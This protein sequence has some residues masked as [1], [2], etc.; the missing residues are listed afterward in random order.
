MTDDVAR[1]R[2]AAAQMRAELA[3]ESGQP[4]DPELRYLDAVIRLI[5]LAADE[6]VAVDRVNDRSRQH[7]ERP[8]AATAP[9]QGT[10]PSGPPR[11]RPSTPGRR[12]TVGEDS[13]RVRSDDTGRRGPVDRRGAQDL[14][15]RRVPSLEKPKIKKTLH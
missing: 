11:C 13:E 14:T 12:R 7:A 4:G 9:A 3:D 15:R 6:S 10:G 8:A 2:A 5:E 1:T